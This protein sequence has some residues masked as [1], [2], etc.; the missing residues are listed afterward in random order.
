MNITPIAREVLRRRALRTDSWD[1]QALRIQAEELRAMLTRAADTRFGREHSFRDIIA[2]LDTSRRLNA[3]SDE[4]LAAMIDTY[5][6]AVPL[7]DYETYR[8]PIMEMVEGASDILWPGVCLNYAQSSGTSGGRSKYIPIT[9]DALHVNHYGG[10]RD[11]VAFYLDANPQSRL[12][13]GKAFILG[14]SFESELTP[15]NPKVKVGDLS[16]SLIANV[17]P[18]VKI[19]RIPSLDTALMS[20][21]EKKLPALAQEAAYANVTNISGVPSWFMRVL[22]KIMEIRGANHIHEV[23]PNLEVFFHGG[24]SFKPYREEYRRICPDE[25]MHYFETYNASEGFFAVQRDFDPEHRGMTLI[26]DSGVVYD[27][28]PLGSETPVAIDDLQ[29]GKVYELVITNMAGLWRYRIGDTVRIESVHP[30]RIS[31]AGRTKSFINAFGEELMEDNADKAIAAASA[32]T[33]LSVANY[34]A[35]PLYA[36]EGSK[37]RHQWMVEWGSVSTPSPKSV[38]RFAEVLDAT[39]REVNSDYAAKRAGDIFLDPPE[40][41]TLPTGTFNRWLSRQGNGKLGGQRKIPRLCNDRSIADTI[42]SLQP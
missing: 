41:I 32:A 11:S 31:I 15:A 4:R 42:L 33:G 3:A 28:L 26:I 29:V 39:L 36:R 19:Y 5:R 6:Q 35:A 37:G 21:W 8:E 17:S 40:V 13:S 38:E 12:F 14:G 22:L 27:F 16:A 9:D 2:D 10:G 24:I 34:T 23:W 1:T 7:A 30:L 18:F 25:K 20:D